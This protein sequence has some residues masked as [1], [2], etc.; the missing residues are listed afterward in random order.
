VTAALVQ[1][2]TDP[3]LNHELIRAQT[4]EKLTRLGLDAERVFIL[5]EIGGNLGS[6]LRNTLSLLQRRGEPVVFSAVLHHDDCLAAQAG[7]RQPLDRVATQLRTL[8]VEHALNIPVHT[9]DI[10]TET[11]AVSWSDEPRRS[12]ETIGFRMPR[13]FG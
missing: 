3:R 4:I 6:N 12:Y 11:S 2:C 1:V 10:L 13:M 5:N 9:G 8:L 7:L